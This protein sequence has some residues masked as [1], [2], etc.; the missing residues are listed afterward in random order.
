MIF[1]TLRQIAKD[2]NYKLPSWLEKSVEPQID[3]KEAKT[4]G[5]NILLLHGLFGA[6]SNWDSIFD[7]LKEFANPIAISFP[8]ATG[9]ISDISV[10][11]LT[12]LTEYFI[13]KN[14]F[15]DLIVCGNSLGGH[16]ALKL[17]LESPN[18][19][20]KLILSGSSGLYEH[21]V[22]KLP[23]KPT[24]SF[25]YDQM[26]KVF[27]NK[28]FIT[29]DGI[30]SILDSL[31]NKKVFLNYVIAA[32]SAKHDNLEKVLPNIS[33][34]TLLLWGEDDEVTPLD[35]AHTFNK[36]ISN[37]TLKTIKSCGHAPM[38]E[39]P[40]WFANEILNFINN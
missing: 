33:K 29:D 22:E 8:I 4:K 17:A 13:R 38:I 15:K 6:V 11:S 18:I 5:R 30:K 31:L 24:S 9:K 34:E 21:Q 12:L 19:F 1:D 26:A 7:L 3:F 37:S 40:K 25:V 16:I 20:D 27:Y 39:Y 10:S 32:K 14:D 28:D 23:L 2:N 36:L 35:I